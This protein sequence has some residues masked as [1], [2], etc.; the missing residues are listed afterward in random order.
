MILSQSHHKMTLVQAK[1]KFH[2]KEREKTNLEESEIL[3]KIF[4]RREKSSSQ[5][6]QFPTP[7]LRFNQFIWMENLNDWLPKVE[8]AI[9]KNKKIKS[10]NSG[11]QFDI[12]WQII[13]SDIGFL[14]PVSCRISW[15]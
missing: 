11:D 10:L 15:Q 13:T 4:A 1:N 8:I 5:P 14:F 7:L 9:L 12:C 3:H 6:Y 2:H